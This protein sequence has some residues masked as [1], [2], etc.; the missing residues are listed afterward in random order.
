MSDSRK[1]E[2]GIFFWR[3]GCSLPPRQENVFLNV[4]SHLWVFW[5]TQKLLIL[6]GVCNVRVVFLQLPTTVIKINIEKKRISH[7]LHQNL[8]SF[9]LASTFASAE[10]CETGR[11]LLLVPREIQLEACYLLFNSPDNMPQAL[12]RPFLLPRKQCCSLVSVLH[13]AAELVSSREFCMCTRRELYEWMKEIVCS[14]WQGIDQK[15]YFPVAPSSFQ[16]LQLTICFNERT[17]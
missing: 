12:R 1:F 10:V 6:F 13:V 3:K 11:G 14:G 2:G 15:S 9:T 16:C 8:L 17:I 7:V 4:L 5:Q